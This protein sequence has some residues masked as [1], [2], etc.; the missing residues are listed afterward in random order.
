MKRVRR[1]HVV[2]VVTAEALAEAGEA[3]AEVVAAVAEA[4]VAEAEAV[5]EA[6]VAGAMAAATGTA[7]IAGASNR[8]YP[9]L[10]VHKP[11]NIMRISSPGLRFGDEFDF[12]AHVAGQ[13]RHLYG[14][15]CGRRFAEIPCVDLIHRGKF[16]H[17]GKKDSR[18]EH[19]VER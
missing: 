13:A 11:Q 9:A 3:A 14:C 18:L 5:A 4:V 10:G 15:A 16:A 19:L 8:D 7:E 6:V 12:N 2:A 17:I 1:R